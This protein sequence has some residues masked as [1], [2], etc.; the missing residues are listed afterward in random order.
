[1]VGGSKAQ[2]PAFRLGICLMVACFAFGALAADAATTTG[3]PRTNVSIRFSDA[4]S[5]DFRYSVR[6]RLKKCRKNRKVIFFH[7]ENGNDRL[8]HREFVIGTGRTNRGQ[9]RPR[10]GRRAAGSRQDRRPG[11]EEQEVRERQDRRYPREQLKR[12]AARPRGARYLARVDLE[13]GQLEADRWSALGNFSGRVS[14]ATLD[15]WA[16]ERGIAAGTYEVREPGSARVRYLF[17][18]GPDGGVETVET[19]DLD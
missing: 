11:Q 4:G 17:R 14:K 3:K 2:P 15:R 16:G 13:I 10:V 7:D 5:N 19:L 1:M 6:V 8:D 18:V 9:V 12:P